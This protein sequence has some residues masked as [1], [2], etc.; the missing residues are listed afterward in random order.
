MKKYEHVKI[1]ELAPDTSHG[2]ILSQIRAES[3]V[4]ELGCAR[5]TMTEYMRDTLKCNVDIVEIDPEYYAEAREFASDGICA[6]LCKNEWYEKFREGRYD[7]VLLADVL[8]HL[9]TPESVMKK[10][11]TL[12]K[13]DGTLIFSLP[14]IAH[15]DIL[16]K[17]YNNHFDY[18]SM[19]LLDNTHIHFF[20]EKNIQQLVEQAGLDIT[21]F[22]GTRCKVGNTE[23]KMDAASQE[24]QRVLQILGTKPMG[25][26][27]QFVCTAQLR[28]Y[29]KSKGIQCINRLERDACFPANEELFETSIQIAFDN[30]KDY[31]G[32]A[33]S[34]LRSEMSVVEEHLNQSKEQQKAIE[35]DLAVKNQQLSDAR[36]LQKEYYE[37]AQQSGIEKG[38]L[39]QKISSFEDAMIKL[40]KQLERAQAEACETKKQLGRTQSESSVIRKQLAQMQVAVVEMQNSRSWRMTRKCRE[41]TDWIRKKP[42]LY[43][44]LRLIKKGIKPDSNASKQSASTPSEQFENGIC[45][46]SKSLIAEMVSVVIPIYDR[47]DV[48]RESIQSILTQTYQD[49]ELI[50]VCDGSPQ[51][52]LDIVDSYADDPRVRIYKYTDNS[53][54]SVRGRNRAIQEARGEYL[55]FQDSDDIAEPTRLAVSINYIKKYNVDVVYGAWRA[56]VEDRIVDVENGQIVYSPECDYNF[57]KETC[58]PCQST[59]MVRTKALRDVGGLKSC[60]RYREDH[61][62]WARLAYFGYKFKAIN[63]VLTTLRLHG[64]NLEL[65]FKDDD[66]K[67]KKLML[68]QHK[69]RGI[70][71]KRI[72]FIIG[73]CTIGGGMKV[74]CTYAKHLQKQGYYVCMLCTGTITPI[75]WISDFNIEIFPINQAPTDFDVLISTFWL[76]DYYLDHIP[77]KKKVYLVQSDERKFYDPQSFEPTAVEK[78]YKRNSREFVVI[79]QWMKI[80]LKKEFNHNATLIT[81]G[82]EYE[83]FNDAA[84]LEHRGKRLRVLIEGPF[85]SQLKGV[86]TA[87]EIVKGLNVEV[88]YVSPTTI[89]SSVSADR[90]FTQ[91]PSSEMP[92]I[93][94]SCDVLL[95][96]SQYESFCLPALE[97]M[98]TGGIAVVAQVNGVEEFVKN[99]YNGYIFD[100]GDTVTARKILKTLINDRKL[101]TELKQNA[102]DTAAQYDWKESLAKLTAFFEQMTK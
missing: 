28:D 76:T 78:T 71:P 53:G 52:T 95:K 8:E 61:E 99:G 6:D 22:D 23:Q 68:E 88:W 33:I 56:L 20:G 29:V 10:A 24:E 74:I 37:K 4:L 42:K 34:S 91:V 36:A 79:A 98:A 32:Q 51:A 62:L 39:Q 64:S 75:N 60:M 94:A 48:L 82:I 92:A 83:D 101:L 65:S 89:P 73:G 63:E 15:G 46:H 14:N 11:A 49:L 90:V 80:W 27:Y 18:T 26:V 84:P 30:I 102:K 58:V 85:E 25:Q 54:N 40:Q 1:E 38:L 7:Y 21:I 41:L 67:W 5:G 44:G 96:T 9:S 50:L 66:K 70:L 2:L 43:A 13:D 87:F 16:F 93:Y 17:L 72:G 19:G 12:L 59:V 31:Y 47:T 81:N 35:I 55:A 45:E 3:T 69:I 57:L 86:G 77:A 97:I 100:Q